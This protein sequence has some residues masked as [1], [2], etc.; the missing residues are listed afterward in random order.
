MLILS[1]LHR[2]IL[3]S[4]LDGFAHFWAD[5]ER[6]SHISSLQPGR[7]PERTAVVG[8]SQQLTRSTSAAAPMDEGADD[9]QHVMGIPSMVGVPVHS[10]DEDA[11]KAFHYQY[12]VASA[13][14]QR[15]YQ[16]YAQYNS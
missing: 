11:R 3:V 5:N 13:W 12:S 4:L 7:Q 6:F 9:S 15:W 8:I 10:K 14:W 2:P 1:H 16:W